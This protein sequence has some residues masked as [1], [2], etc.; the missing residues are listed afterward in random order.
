MGR[1]KE[2]VSIARGRWKNVSYLP[3]DMVPG[4]R[5]ENKY[6]TF[7]FDLD[8]IDSRPQRLCRQLIGSGEE[9]DESVSLLPRKLIE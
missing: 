4:I 3:S 1:K 5:I 7:N 6:R 9:G 2:V 8:T